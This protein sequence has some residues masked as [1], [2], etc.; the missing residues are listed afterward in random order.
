MRLYV[1]NYQIT[2][3]NN[4]SPV[5]EMGM[6]APVA[7]MTAGTDYHVHCDFM[8]IADSGESTTEMLSKLQEWINGNEINMVS[9]V[10]DRPRCFYCGTMVDTG[11]AK[12]QYYGGE[13]R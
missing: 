6:M 3:N 9:A 4:I 8:P 5:R 2:A 1:T 13:V 7:L 10:R 12:C 11:A